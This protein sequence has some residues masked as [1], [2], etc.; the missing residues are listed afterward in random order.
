MSERL[1]S[2]GVA[3]RPRAPWQL[4]GNRT[5]FVVDAVDRD[6]P[7]V[8]QLQ[9]CLN[10]FSGAEFARLEQDPG[11]ADGLWKRCVIA[12]SN[13]QV[14]L[15]L[16]Q[17]AP[18]RPTTNVVDASSSTITHSK[19]RGRLSGDLKPGVRGGADAQTSSPTTASPQGSLVDAFHAGIAAGP[20]PPPAEDLR[21]P[22]KPPDISALMP[23][24]DVDHDRRRQRRPGERRTPQHPRPSRL[25]RPTPR[26]RP[27]APQQDLQTSRRR[28]PR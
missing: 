26:Q 12:T 4:R 25:H 3:L 28:L 23:W 22:G 20:K 19:P 16:M 10:P 14:A 5:P 24:M 6:W 15:D 2:G 11:H 7:R 1:S 13:I 27:R 9:R 18:P 8:V 21:V 17:L